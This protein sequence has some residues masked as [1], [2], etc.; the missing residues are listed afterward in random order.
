MDFFLYLKKNIIDNAKNSSNPSGLIIV[1]IDITAKDRIVKN[2][3][4]DKNKTNDIEIE[5]MNK[6][7]GIPNKEF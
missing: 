6:G 5:I 7:S 4:S 2:F 1:A 3:L